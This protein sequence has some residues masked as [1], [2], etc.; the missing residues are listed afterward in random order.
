MGGLLPVTQSWG[1][2]LG[3]LIPLGLVIALSP[4]T[5]I[6]A[7]L[8]LQAPRP[9]PSGLAFLAG[10]VLGL[11]ALTAVS[12]AGSGLLGGLHKPAPRWASWLRVILGAALIV[13]G[14][15]RWFTRHRHTESPAWMRS[16]ATI[17][18][19]RAAITGAVLVVIRPDVLLIC[20]PAGL[21]IG[22]SG[23][24]VVDDWIAAAFFVAIAASTVAIPV[25]AYAAA[26]HRLDDAMARLKDWMDKNNAALMAAILV[27]IGLMVLYNGIHAL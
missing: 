3:A 27:V 20:V 9:R 13:F 15:Y 4:I 10:W 18:P 21:A 7:V 8:V 26:G 16:F 1:S 22:G 25:L 11:A 5:V 14:I 19:A 2:V 23:K 17:T 6:P 12:V 24:D